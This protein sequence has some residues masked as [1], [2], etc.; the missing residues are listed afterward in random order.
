MP[1]E[2]AMTSCPRCGETVPDSSRYCG[3]CGASVSQE[4]LNPTV[5]SA[6]A[7]HDRL[8]DS[9]AMQLRQLLV[10]ETQGE[11]VIDAELGRGGMAVVYRATEVHLS[12]PVA[13]KVLPPELTFTKGA[14]ERFQREAKTAAALDHPNIIPIHRISSGGRLFW[15]AMKYLEGRS[16]AEI[17]QEKG[18]LTVSETIAILEQVGSALDYAHQR[19]VVHRDIK[20]GNVMLDVNGRVTVTDFGIAKELTAG[21]LT[22]SGAILG[23]PYYMSPEQCR[24][25]SSITGAADQYSLGV[26]A[27]QMVCGQLPF[28]ADS[29]IDV[30]H[31]HVA[32]A[33]PPLDQ[34]LPGLPKHVINAIMRAMSKKATDRFPTVQALV[35]A[36]KNVPA[37]ATLQMEKRQAPRASR[38][39]SAFDKA[40]AI[41]ASAL[42]VVGGM[43]LIG[44]L[45]AGVLYLNNRTRGEAPTGSVAFAPATNPAPA[46]ATQSQP[47]ADTG[48]AAQPSEDSGHAAQPTLGAPGGAQ[49]SPGPTGTAQP[50]PGPAGT[51]KAPP[52]RA[53]APAPATSRTQAA[54]PP[55]QESKRESPPPRDTSRGTAKAPAPSAPARTPTTGAAPVSTQ[56]TGTASA[57]AA[58]PET[59]AAAPAAR[60]GVLKISIA[61]TYAN[62][63][64]PGRPLITER[65]GW[66]GPISSGPHLITVT[67]DG[68]ETVTKPVVVK[69]GQDTTSVTV[70]IRPRSQP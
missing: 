14:S 51:T 64:I 18:L 56:A 45:V 6:V 62:I 3:R 31:K 5:A 25:G 54:T 32:E 48:H 69:A 35:N 15:Y 21:A 33:P 36:M 42:R 57:P 13:I 61:P 12:R 63:S 4:L 20:P 49:P 44:G 16:L 47:P 58:A 39:P 53:V 28:E 9:G 38:R 55:R 37:D 19:S 34:V 67:R 29:A 23:T 27:Y 52:P 22:G 7:R 10:T 2:A 17:L 24:G 30:I 41:K 40:P 50:S 1:N 46:P 60:M 65:R 68:Y 43:V 66:V 11:Y 59:P 8:S 70:T 26:M